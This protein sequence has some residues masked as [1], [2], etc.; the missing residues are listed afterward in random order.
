M[1]KEISKDTKHFEH[2]LLN[3]FDR[4]YRDYINSAVLYAEL[5]IPYEALDIEREIRWIK[6]WIQENTTGATEEV[7]NEKANYQGLL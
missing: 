6:S 3:K 7:M 2:P 1:K 4:E 5:Q